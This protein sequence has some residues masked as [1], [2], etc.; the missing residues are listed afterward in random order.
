MHSERELL[1][2]IRDL[3]SGGGERDDLASM[4]GSF[5]AQGVS[6][7]PTIL[8]VHGGFAVSRPFNAGVTKQST[9]W[10][11]SVAWD[12]P[13]AAAAQWTEQ[14]ES[15][16]RLV[17]RGGMAVSTLCD[18][19]V[20]AR[21]VCIHQTGEDLSGYVEQTGETG[22]PCAGTVTVTPGL[23][24]EWSVGFQL[25][26]TGGGAP[27]PFRRLPRFSQCV[28]NTSGNILTILEYGRLVAGAFV[29]LG[30]FDLSGSPGIPETA[31]VVRMAAN[32]DTPVTLCVKG[33]S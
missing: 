10:R 3:L 23:P 29:S 1:E 26:V 2:Q 20:S 19:P 15:P 16:F 33:F 28:S 32:I 30:S 22:G 14:A 21:G 11:V 13:D 12:D 5:T 24:R 8:P 7:L 4:G 18:A 17:T 27:G 31:T 6:P 25:R 9:D